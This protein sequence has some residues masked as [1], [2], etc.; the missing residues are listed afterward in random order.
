MVAKAEAVLERMR[1]A[2]TAAQRLQAVK[3]VKNQ[4]IGNKSKKLSY[5]KL[6]AVSEICEMLATNAAGSE[7]ESRLLEQCAT[8]A[9]SF[10]HGLDVGVQALLDSGKRGNIAG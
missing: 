3:E 8:C 5:I 1:N 9:G 10:A 7:S 6:G 2:G 4:I